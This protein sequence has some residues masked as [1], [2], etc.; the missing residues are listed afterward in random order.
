MFPPAVDCARAQSFTSSF[1]SRTCG[2]ISPY[3]IAVYDV[4][5]LY[6]NCYRTIAKGC[7]HNIKCSALAR[8]KFDTA[9]LDE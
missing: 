6:L 7:L 2:P 4:S 5:L 8:Q 9:A 1:P 3:F